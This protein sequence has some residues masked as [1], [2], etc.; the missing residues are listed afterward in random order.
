MIREK[1][2]GMQRRCENKRKSAMNFGDFSAR[3]RKHMKK[4]KTANPMVKLL[5]LPMIFKGWRVFARKKLNGELSFD[6]K[7][8]SPIKLMR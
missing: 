8:E 6:E 3:T 1:I 7:N 5:Y 2:Y 4:K